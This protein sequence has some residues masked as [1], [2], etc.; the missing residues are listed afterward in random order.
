MGSASR[1]P[2]YSVVKKTDLSNRISTIEGPLSPAPGNVLA[3]GSAP[4]FCRDYGLRFYGLVLIFALAL[5]CASKAFGETAVLRV[6]EE[7]VP[8]GTRDLQLRVVFQALPA[9][10]VSAIQFDL[11]FEAELLKLSKVEAG[12]SA[13]AAN[14]GVSSYVV[15]PGEQRIIVAGMNQNTLASGEV[16]LLHVTLLEAPESVIPVQLVSELLS[17]PVG[18]AV[19]VTS[20]SGRIFVGDA[21]AK[22]GEAGAKTPSGG[23]SS[24]AVYVTLGLGGVVLLAGVCWLRWGRR[25]PPVKKKGA[26]RTSKPKKRR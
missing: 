17:S 13:I 1:R 19:S 26:R 21:Q 6:L 25:K 22:E 8:A 9:A 23:G 2:S 15:R 20:Q 5:F 7:R 14:K 16:A 24:P 10:P 18:K 11:H 3:Q 4:R 12:A